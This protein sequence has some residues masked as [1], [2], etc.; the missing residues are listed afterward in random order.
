[1][2]G[3][4]HNM[5]L[6]VW[7]NRIR[8]VVKA[9]GYKIRGFLV[10][11]RRNLDEILRFAVK[12]RY[13]TTPGTKAQS[14]RAPTKTK[15]ASEVFWHARGNISTDYMENGKRITK[16]YYLSLLHQLS[17]EIRK[18]RKSFSTMTLRLYRLI[19]LRQPN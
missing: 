16:E 1:M 19:H 10:L 12:P 18:R 13:T 11:F 7:R 3:K 4:I 6:S 2:I 5:L 15:L 17:D 14:K 9:A 8:K